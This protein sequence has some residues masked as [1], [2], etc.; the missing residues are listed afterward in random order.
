MALEKA[1]FNR[2]DLAKAEARLRRIGRVRAKELLNDL[3][4]LEL[5]LKGSHSN[6]HRARFVLES[7]IV[8]LA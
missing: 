6:E 5:Q 1:G 7:L 8:S 4:R 2:F 3:V